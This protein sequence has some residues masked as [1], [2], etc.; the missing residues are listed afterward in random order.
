M[1]KPEKMFGLGEKNLTSDEIKQC[2][3]VKKNHF[4]RNRKINFYKL[5]L[6]IMSILKRANQI[7]ID[8]IIKKLGFKIDAEMTY[9]KQ[10]FSEAR[11][12]LSPNAFKYLIDSFVRDYYGDG[13]FKKYKKFILFAIDGCVHEI[14]NTIE[15]R[16]IY[17]YSNNVQKAE[18]ARALTGSMYD[19]EN[20]LI[21]SSTF[22]RYDG[23]ERENAKI[24]IEKSLELLPQT[25]RSLVIFDRG[26]PSIEFINYL[27]IK[28]VS[29]LM[30]V[31]SVK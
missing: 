2:G 6:L 10:A 27:N 24:M 31:A 23:S 16:K 8:D 3:T 7:D 25:E 30:R 22:G 5:I 26:Y 19:L 17:G 28:G 9:T 21:V 12:K 20:R 11:Q 1:K 29:F 15:N 4:T 14:P 13:E 18:L